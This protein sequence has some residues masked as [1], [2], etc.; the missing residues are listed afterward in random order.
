MKITFGKVH[1]DHEDGESFM[2]VDSEGNTAEFYYKLDIHEEGGGFGTFTITDTCDRYMPFDFS[3]LDEL[4]ELIRMLKTYRD[5]KIKFDNY[6][7]ANWG[8]AE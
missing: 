8:V 7:K 4:Y 3:Q 5:D 1:P 2:G 6:W